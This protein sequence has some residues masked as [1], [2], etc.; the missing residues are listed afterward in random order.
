M[1]KNITIKQLYE[2]AVDNE[3][4][5]YVVK[6]QYRDEGGDYLGADEE[7]YCNIDHENKIVTL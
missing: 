7:I 1:N 6:I 2:W 5:D 4:D 3:C